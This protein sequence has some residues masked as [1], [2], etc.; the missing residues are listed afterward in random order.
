M[1]TDMIGGLGRAPRRRHVRKN[2]VLLH[3]WLIVLWYIAVITGG[4]ALMFSGWMRDGMGS[5][6]MILYMLYPVTVLIESAIIGYERLWGWWAVLAPILMGTYMVLLEWLFKCRV[7][8]GWDEPDFFLFWF[9]IVAGSVGLAMGIGTYYIQKAGSPF[10]RWIPYMLMWVL[11]IV[12][13]WSPH[14]DSFI[15]DFLFFQTTLPALSFAMG[16]FAG[17]DEYDSDNDKKRWLIVPKM[18]ALFSIAFLVTDCIRL[19]FFGSRDWHY[20]SDIF[21]LPLLAFLVTVA[22]MTVIG[23][24][25]GIF[26]RRRV[27]N[28]V[29]QGGGETR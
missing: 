21:I 19:A 22:V 26:V 24:A 12:A 8:G 10:A 9:A 16:F 28:D 6:L 18:M 17:R 14:V 1:R 2:T 20:F 23:V 27:Q 13:Y 25:L 11:G 4:V 3:K 29:A 5:V 15:V 7:Y